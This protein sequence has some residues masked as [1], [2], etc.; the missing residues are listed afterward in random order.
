M[1]DKIKCGKTAIFPQKCQYILIAK[2]VLINTL[3]I[4]EKNNYC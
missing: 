3:Q 4:Y 2:S 1:V